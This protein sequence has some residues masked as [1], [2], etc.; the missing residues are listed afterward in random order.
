M[1]DDAKI[2]V[3]D[4]DDAIRKFLRIS[5][6]ASGYRVIEAR[7][8]EGALGKAATESPALVVLDLGLPD[9]DGREVV[10]RLR[11]WFTGPILILSVR[12]TE[13][14]K[15]AVLDAGADDFVVKPFG[16]QELLA[17]VRA[18]L[19]ARPG[20]PEAPTLDLGALKVDLA[21]RTVTVNGREIG[22]TRKEFD[23][24]ALLVRS[25]GKVVTQRQLLADLWGEAHVHDTQYLRVYVGQIRAKLGDD[26]ANPRFIRTEPGIGYRLLVGA[27]DMPPSV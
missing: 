16:V 20:V 7:D 27:S 18:L 19:R 11:D 26:P 15:V 12:S 6:T 24:L 4:D 22:L 23:L 2:L 25:A 1:P 13:E 9:L 21:A 10:S 8:G 5:L 17:R 14:E 3:V